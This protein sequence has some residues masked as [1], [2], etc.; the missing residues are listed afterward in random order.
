VI[1]WIAADEE[2]FDAG[3]GTRY[4]PD[5][6]SELTNRGLTIEEGDMIGSTQERYPD[7]VNIY[8]EHGVA[9]PAGWL[10]S[11]ISHYDDQRIIMHR[12]HKKVWM[13]NKYS[14]SLINEF[15]VGDESINP[16]ASV[17]AIICPPLS[18]AGL[19]HEKSTKV[20]RMT[21]KAMHITPKDFPLWYSA[22]TFFAEEDI[23]I[24]RK[25]HE[26]QNPLYTDVYLGKEIV[27]SETIVGIACGGRN[28]E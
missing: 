23:Q 28:N 22:A 27:A 20:L 11:V 10:V 17:D 9:Y 1:L 12:A 15:V 14:D 21:I 19:K 5:S 24:I 4:L 3:F 8:V 18:L 13:G 6:I 7:A 26:L 2:T 25:N 16:F